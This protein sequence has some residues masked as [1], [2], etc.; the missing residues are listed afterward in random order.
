LRFSEKLGCSGIYAFAAVALIIW[1][2]ERGV[3]GESAQKKKKKNSTVDAP[4]ANT[5]ITSQRRRSSRPRG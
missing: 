5:T 4:F 1:R 3:R 2:V